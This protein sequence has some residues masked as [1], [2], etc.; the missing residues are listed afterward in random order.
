MSAAPRLEFAIITVAQQG[1]VVRIG[2]DENVPTVAAISTRR[3]AARDVFLPPKCDAAI[4]AVS[5]LYRYFCFVGKHVFTRESN[6][7]ALYD[8]RRE[9]IRQGWGERQKS[10]PR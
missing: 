2:F 3:S 1:V 7:K 5:G 9:I 6:W 8:N 10:A 4:A